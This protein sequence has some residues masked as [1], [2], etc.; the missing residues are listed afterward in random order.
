MNM[1][2]TIKKWQKELR[3]YLLFR[4]KYKEFDGGLYYELS[5][6]RYIK[7]SL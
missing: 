3:A 5:E 1:K 7:I 2:K 6:N 4:K